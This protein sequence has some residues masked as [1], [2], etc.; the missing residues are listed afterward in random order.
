MFNALNPGFLP[1]TRIEREG[2]EFDILLA[3]TRS[4]C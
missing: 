2:G 4:L 1:K 3:E